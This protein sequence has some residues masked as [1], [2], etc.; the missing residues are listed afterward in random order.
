MGAHEH[1]VRLLNGPGSPAPR[2]IQDP[3]QRSVKA[4]SGH[5]LPVTTG[6][7]ASPAVR[8][9]FMYAKPL[10]TPGNVFIVRNLRRKSSC[11][12][13]TSVAQVIQENFLQNDTK[14]PDH[15]Q[16]TMWTARLGAKHPHDH[17]WEHSGSQSEVTMTRGNSPR[18]RTLRS[19]PVHETDDEDPRLATRSRRRRLIPSRATSSTVWVSAFFLAPMIGSKFTT[20]R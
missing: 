16:L 4:R 18:E 15:D 20:H 17:D 5:A 11:H 8:K 2:S 6:T 1:E 10:L 3:H 19:S 9:Q 12:V 14:P 13:S 7:E